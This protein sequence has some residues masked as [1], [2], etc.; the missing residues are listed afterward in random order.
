MHR[1]SFA[2]LALA[3]LSLC[4]TAHAAPQTQGPVKVFVLAGQ[5]NMVGHGKALNGRNPAFDPAQPPAADNPSEIPGGIGGLAW[6]V[7]TMP[8]TYGSE[9]TDPLVDAEGAWLVRGDVQVHARMEVFRNRERPGELTPGVTRKGPHTIGFGKAD[10]RD[11]RWIGPEYGFGHVV[12]DALEE[13]VLLVKVAT[14]GTSLKFDWRSPSAVAKRGG[15][16]GYMWTHL[17]ATVRQVLDDLESGF[18]DLAG[19]SVEIAGFGWHQGWND[20]TTEGVVEY[21]ANLADLIHDVRSEFG[22]TLP[23]VV[24]N[25]GIGGPDLDGVGLQLVEAQGAVADPARHP[26]HAGNVVVVD[27]RPMYRDA[28]V[29]PSGFGY[30]WNHNGVAHYRIGAGMGRAW[31][32]LVGLPAERTARG[33]AKMPWTNPGYATDVPAT[34]A[35]SRPDPDESPD[36]WTLWMKH[37]EDRKRWCEEQPVDLLM[38]GD[39]IVF[40]WS[41]VGRPVW[42]EYYADRNAVNIGS[43]GDRT[44]HML[45]HFQHGGLDG[46]A[47]HDPKLVVLMIGTNNRGAP[48]RQGADT[49]YGVLALLKEIHAR[50]PD[51]KILL[52]AIFPRGDAPTDEGRRRNDR[53]NAILQEFA[54]GETVHWLDLSGVFLNRDGT[55]RRDLL[56]DGLHPGEEGFRAWAEAMEPAIVR[57]LGEAR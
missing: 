18:P 43:S 40:R 49:A 28:A 36:S 7:E 42:E 39:S 48:E 56:P 5:S 12:G 10:S 17:L 2:A 9:G 19:R 3:A 46:M 29:S 54:D 55:L 44:E 35:Q 38:I 25:T 24:A 26:E 6:A 33:G 8:Y 4:C 15:E 47:E 32:T 23:V 52:L 51:S 27:T 30:H 20:R 21:E 31:L 22:A 37:H 34:R 50:L 53:V 14:G 13:P 16:V 1:S 57:L 11:Q 45:W 41:R